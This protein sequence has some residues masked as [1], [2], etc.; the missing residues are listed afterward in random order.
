MIFSLFGFSTRGFFPF[1]PVGGASDAIPR[2]FSPLLPLAHV[3]AHACEWACLLF[4][5]ACI[6]ICSAITRVVRGSEG[7]G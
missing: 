3:C 1:P 2:H 5:D 6:N 4:F 7:D